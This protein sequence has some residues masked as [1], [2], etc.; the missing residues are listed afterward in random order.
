[1]SIKTCINTSIYT[2]KI[3]KARKLLIIYTLFP[4][5]SFISHYVYYIILIVRS[6]EC[7]LSVNYLY[8]ENQ[9]RVKNFLF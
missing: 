4:K 1:M 3:V 6:K 9:Y 5:D 7:K 8:N 2:E